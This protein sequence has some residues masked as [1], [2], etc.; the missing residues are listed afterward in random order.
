MQNIFPW[1]EK[2][3]EKSTVYKGHIYSDDEENL[4]KSDEDLEF[5]DEGVIEKVKK[6]TSR[7][8]RVDGQTPCWKFFEITKGDERVAKCNKCS[9][10]ITCV[11][12]RGK[13]TTTA[14]NT[15]LQS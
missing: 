14:L 10:L 1:P 11:D 9:A 4:Q 3:K 7:S 6:K 15:H 13:L 2:T 5:L 8:C 12:K